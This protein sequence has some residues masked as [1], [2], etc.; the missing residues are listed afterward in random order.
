MLATSMNNLIINHT[1]CVDMNSD[2]SLNSH[3]HTQRTNY[4]ENL[5]N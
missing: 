5:Y 4:T 1:S 3:T 2:D